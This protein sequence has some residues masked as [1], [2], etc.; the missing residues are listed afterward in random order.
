MARLPECPDCGVDIVDKTVAKKISGRWVC[1]DCQLVRAR[2]QED[3]QEL[4]DLVSEMF[5]MEFPTGMMMKQI[6]DMHKDLN[7][8]YKG[9]TLSLKYWT[10]T[11]GEDMQNAKGVGI[12]PYIYE[13][14]KA[15]Y[16]KKMQVK[17]AVDEMDGV[18]STD[19]E[20]TITK[21]SI[22][23]IRKPNHNKMID[24]DEL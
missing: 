18:F 1:P 17:K 2:I 5:R 11:L 20:V 19:R 7:Y 3:R 6:A 14:A 23:E 4:Y 10:E 22:K 21:S 9:M 12:I 16:I 13:D 8:T 15:F 24:M